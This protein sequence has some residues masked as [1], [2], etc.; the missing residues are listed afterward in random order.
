MQQNK[1][2]KSKKPNTIVPFF[3]DELG[4]PA[5]SFDYA[6]IHKSRW[7]KSTRQQNTKT[8]KVECFGHLRKLANLLFELTEVLRLLLE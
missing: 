6:Q 1:A 8:Q 5:A 2:M 3:K 4:R 7:E